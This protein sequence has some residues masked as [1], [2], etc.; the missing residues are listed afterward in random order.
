M[1][2][3]QLNEVLNKALNEGAGAAVTIYFDHDPHNDYNIN[4]DCEVNMKE[5]K[6]I[7]KN[8]LIADYYYSAIAEDGGVITFNE[9][10]LK[11]A[12]VKDYNN[13]EK[14][15]EEP[16]ITELDVSDVY[17]GGFES[18][19]PVTYGGGWVRSTCEPGTI[20]TWEKEY[21]KP[22]IEIH[23]VVNGQEY[24]LM[25][26]CNGEYHPS[27]EACYIISDVEAAERAQNPDMYDDEDFE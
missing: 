27:D 17:V 23:G 14:D 8:I 18:I 13:Y 11:Q 16:D 19:P 2:I 9:N 12:F 4:S 1:N 26:E 7:L 20:I 15:V 3:K 25:I 22:N 6:I 24:N 5:N 10:E 21:N